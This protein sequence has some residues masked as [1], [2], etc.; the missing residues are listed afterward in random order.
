MSAAE[1]YLSRR[2]C[3]SSS[4]IRRARSAWPASAQA[5]PRPGAELRGGGREAAR[6]AERGEGVVRPLHPQVRLA[7]EEVG[8]REARVGLQGLLERGRRLHE[9]PG[10]VVDEPE[11]RL[12][13]GRE[14]VGLLRQPDLPGRLVE[15]AHRHEAVHRVPV[16]RGRVL[17]VALDGLAEVPLGL[18]PGP[19]VDR[20]DAAEGRVD[21]G[22]A[23]VGLPGEG[24]LGRL[25]E[26]AGRRR[27]RLRHDLGR[28]TDPVDAEEHV[29]VGEAGVGAGVPRVLV[30]RLLEVLEAAEEAVLGPLVPLVA[31]PEVEP[32]DLGRAGLGRHERRVVRL[33]EGDAQRGQ[34][35]PRD[36]VLDRE[37]VLH[38]PV[39]L[40]RPDLVAVGRVRQPGPDPHPLPGGAD[41]SLEEGR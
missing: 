4:R 30:D 15:A 31:A 28:G 20:L 21:G 40:R 24:V 38:L 29:G 35:A 39:V 34:D 10:E 8:H 41:A 7:Q 18:R 33:D 6:V 3:F 5:L 17:G 2:R 11:A 9:A 27:L 23:G 1:T 36:L 12:D 14:G 37:D 22:E 26:G 19:V 32:V 13:G 16:V 25:L